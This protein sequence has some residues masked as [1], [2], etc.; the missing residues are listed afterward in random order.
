MKPNKTY[1]VIIVLA[2]WMMQDGTLNDETRARVDR[3]CQLHKL[4]QAEKILLMGWDYREDTDLCVSD[5][6]NAYLQKQ[7]II[8]P[9]DVYVDRI[10]RDSVGDA[11]FSR[12]NF[13]HVIGNQAICVVTSDYHQFRTRKIFNFVY[14][15]EKKIDVIGVE[16]GRE[17]EM[18]E[19][20]NASLIAFDKTF[21]NV[22]AGKIDLIFQT[23]IEKHPYYNGEVYSKIGI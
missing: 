20:E 11:I 21:E 14:G 9:S 22:P 5:A 10:S 7:Y 12:L 15:S 3:A 2:N 16:T 18:A 23:I 19:T 6:M 4:G 13:S 1:G 17:N 8:N